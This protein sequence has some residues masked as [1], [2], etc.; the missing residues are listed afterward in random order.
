[1][2]DEKPAKESANYG[3]LMVGCFI[4]A[5]A[6]FVLNALPWFFAFIIG[7]LLLFFGYGILASPTAKSKIAGIICIIAGILTILSRIPVIKQP[8]GWFLK[9]GAFAL[10]VMAVWNG[11]KLALSIKNRNS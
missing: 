4:G 6:L 10:L 2:S 7:G 11:I 9:A 5:V 8:A 1:M 3:L